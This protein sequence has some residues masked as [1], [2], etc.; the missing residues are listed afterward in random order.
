MPPAGRVR[1]KNMPRDHCALW[2]VRAAVDAL[3]VAVAHR[4]L[5]PSHRHPIMDSYRP[6]KVETPP[7]S[8]Q[9]MPVETYASVVIGSTTKTKPQKPSQALSKP[10]QA[11]SKSRKKKKKKKKNSSTRKEFEERLWGK[12]CALFHED[13]YEELLYLYARKNHARKKNH[14]ATAIQAIVRGCR[15]R[16]K[17]TDEAEAAEAAKAATAIQALLRGSSERKKWKTWKK[18]EN[19]RQKQAQRRH[20]KAD[21]KT[22]LRI[23]GEYLAEAAL[24]AASARLALENAVSSLEEA[25][26]RRPPRPVRATTGLRRHRWRRH[27]AGLPM[28]RAT[29]RV[30]RRAATAFHR[31]RRLPPRPSAIAL[32]TPAPPATHALVSSVSTSAPFP[33]PPPTISLAA[34]SV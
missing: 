11:L 1:L 14:A 27:G 34:P 21:A 12:L 22:N 17:S 9:T 26:T 24:E 3:I 29:S 25:T 30:P 18:K 10:S 20:K 16:K 5:P 15:A 23:E 2:R 4:R 33:N 32:V 13:F 6:L 28:R 31:P 19:R 8:T 7:V